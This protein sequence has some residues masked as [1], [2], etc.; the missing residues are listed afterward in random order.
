M[1]IFHPTIDFLNS[2]ELITHV[3]KTLYTSVLTI[4]AAVA[5]IGSIGASLQQHASAF[6]YD[7]K[8]FK[9]LTKQ[10]E[11]DVLD[12]AARKPPVGDEIQ[13]LLEDYSRNV[14]ELFPSTSP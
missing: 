4:L 8:Q 7:G 3:M 2:N 9:D 12:A 13:K 6:S 5:L 10:L 11:R 1:K 14:L